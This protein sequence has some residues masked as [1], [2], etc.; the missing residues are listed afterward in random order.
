VNDRV[1]GDIKPVRVRLG[2]GGKITG[3]AIISDEDKPAKVPAL[4]ELAHRRRQ[5]LQ[6][7]RLG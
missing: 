6:C 1:G 7:R 2:P 3:V 5:G 4:F